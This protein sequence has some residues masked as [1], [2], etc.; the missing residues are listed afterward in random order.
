MLTDKETE[1]LQALIKVID[2]R[3]NRKAK[4]AFN[5]NDLFT[6]EM[7]SNLVDKVVLSSDF[8]NKVYDEVSNQLS[9]YDLE[10]ELADIK[11]VTNNIDDIIENFIVNN[12]F[13]LRR[14]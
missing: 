8:S 6:D 12:S 7:I 14:M 13:E 9:E 4:E 1:L 3:I 10:V 2:E 11:D 5:I